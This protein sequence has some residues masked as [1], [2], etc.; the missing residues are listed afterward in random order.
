MH[1][2]KEFGLPIVFRVLIIFI[3]FIILSAVLF[4][5]TE[6]VNAL[7]GISISTITPYVTLDSN[8]SCNAGPTAM[9]QQ[10]QVTNSSG[11]T[12]TDLTVTHSGFTNPTLGGSWVGTFAL[13]PGEST[14]RTISTLADGETANLYYFVNYPCYTGSNPPAKTATYTIKVSDGTAPDVTSG[15]LNLTA[16]SEI[17]ANAGGELVSQQIGNGAVLGQIIPLTVRYKF[18]NIGSGADLGI[19][20]AGNATHN[21]GCYRLVSSDVTG[22]SGVT[23]ITTSDDDVLYKTGVSSG[24]G[25]NTI[26][27]VYYLKAVCIGGAGTTTTPYSDMVSGTQQKYTGNFEPALTCTGSKAPSPCEQNFPAPTNPFTITKTASPTSLPSGGTV[28]Y[29]IVVQNI[30]SYTDQK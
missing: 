30:S 5:P 9:Y 21:S 15:T 8:N 1:K 4:K 27:V 7:S 20:P 25:T 3:S 16:R 12:L 23:G 22:V 6:N 26:D 10:I 11:S 28:T 24:G 17:S 13:D 19:Q 29:T 2:T 14:T 18:G